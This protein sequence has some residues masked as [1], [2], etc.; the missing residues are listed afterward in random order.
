M[1]AKKIKYLTL[2]PLED[3]GNCFNIAYKYSLVAHVEIL[4]IFHSQKIIN[5]SK[6]K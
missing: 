3:G 5:A 4:P 6:K 1:L 2:N